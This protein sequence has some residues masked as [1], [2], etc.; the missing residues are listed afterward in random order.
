MKPKLTR[1][2][3]ARKVELKSADPKSRDRL[4]HRLKVLLVVGKMRRENKAA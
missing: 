1:L 3:E 2:I 4:R